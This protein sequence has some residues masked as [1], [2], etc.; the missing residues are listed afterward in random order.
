MS[1]D[2]DNFYSIPNFRF[3][4]YIS[5]KSDCLSQSCQ[6]DVY[7]DKR[8]EIIVITPFFDIKNPMAQDYHISLINLNGN[9]EEHKMDDHK[10]R[11]CTVRYFQD[12]YTQKDY[13]ISADF[14]YKVCV[15]DLGNQPTECTKKL[16][17]EV[18]YEGFIYS[19]LLLFEKDKMFGVVSSLGANSKTKV[20]NVANS[21]I[22]DIADSN[23]LNVYYLDHWYNEAAAEGKKHVIIQCAKNKVLFSEYPSKS[24]YY[25]IDIEEKYP[26]PQCGLV[27]KDGR[28]KDMFVFS[29]TYGLIE[30]Y[31]LVEKQKKQRLE[32][33]MGE[34]H[35]YSFAKWNDQYLLLNDVQQSRIIVFDMDNED[36]N[37]VEY[38]IKS[39]VI[40]PEM[41]FDKYIKKVR[42]PKY[43]ECL[44]TIG[45]DWKLKLY[46]NRAYVDPE[47][48]EE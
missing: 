26:Y 1:F 36:K 13:F 43:G 33:P 7:K 10:S 6:F 34:V 3:K 24:K 16:E 41:E 32:L 19:C 35:L 8:G 39:K 11:V 18:K 23:N 25:S 29:C 27:Y 37:K 20:L 4:E 21:S 47:E 46:V 28:G 2:A 12:P 31:D 9:K 15:W 45:I 14:K 44:L 30:I 17:T 42:H 38:Q 40:C 22:D 48:A 5:E